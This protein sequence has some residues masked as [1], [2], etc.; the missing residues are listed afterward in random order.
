MHFIYIMFCHQEQYAS[1]KCHHLLLSEIVQ[2]DPNHSGLHILF[3]WSNEI[4]YIAFLTLPTSGTH[5]W[6]DE[7]FDFSKFKTI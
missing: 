2:Q 7:S 6:F 5:L 1:L 3:M 4:A